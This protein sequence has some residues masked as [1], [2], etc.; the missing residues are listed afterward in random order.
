VQTKLEGVVRLVPF[1]KVRDE[2]GCWWDNP[3]RRVGRQRK[4][5]KPGIYRCAKVRP[6]TICQSI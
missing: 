5:V 6:F 1:G 3:E 4:P 2:I